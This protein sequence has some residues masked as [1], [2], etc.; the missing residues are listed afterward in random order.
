MEGIAMTDPLF[1]AWCSL[2]IALAAISLAIR[3]RLEWQAVARALADD[4]DARPSATVEKGEEVP[5]PDVAPAP[6]PV[7]ADRRE[8]SAMTGPRLIAVPDLSAPVPEAHEM[9]ADLSR[10]FGAIWAMSDAGTSP[11]A[12][13]RQTGQPIGQVELILGLRRTRA[14]DPRS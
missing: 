8:P 3:T 4:L 12:I 7:R 2:V 11:E 5:P 1:V 9:P 6:R 13:A 14:A 10:R